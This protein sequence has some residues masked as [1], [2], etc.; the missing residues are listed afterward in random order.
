MATKKSKSNNGFLIRENSKS[1]LAKFNNAENEQTIFPNFDLTKTAE[2]IF[3]DPIVNGVEKQFIDKCM[4]GRYFFLKKD[5]EEVEDSFYNLMET[6]YS[7]RVKVLRPLFLQ[8]FRY[9]NAF[10]ELVRGEGTNNVIGINVLDAKYIQPVTKPNGDVIKYKWKIEDPT[11]KKQPEWTPEEVIWLKF[12]DSS[13]GWSPV[14]MKALYSWVLL[15][16]SMRKYVNWLWATG[17]YRVLY[18]LTDAK[19]KEAQDDFLSFMEANDEDPTQP[20]LYRGE[21]EAKMTRSMAETNDFLGLFR[22]IDQQ[23]LVCLR[24]P[25]IDAGIPDASGRSNADAQS[26]NLVTSVAGIKDVVRDGVTNGL[27][28]IMNKGNTIM[29]W[30][31]HDR[32]HKKQIIDEL[33]I[34][35]NM[36]MSEEA[37]KEYMVN[38]GIVFKTKK[39]FEEPE[40]KESV[41]KKD[42]DLMPSRF[43]GEGSEMNKIGTG[44]EASTREDQKRRFW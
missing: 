40:N 24:M 19:N 30:G 41:G 12:Y 27:L 35:K 1:A 3:A 34:F 29:V 10:I 32:F 17:Q 6:F 14:D 25:P 4:E 31:P 36:G 43:N 20:F 39:L 38:N 18:Q 26:N 23:I 9:R 16:N 37:L 28:K 22:Y 5:T 13:E 21:I 7:F 15:K 33:N 44:E 42:I 2:L 8:A 11:S